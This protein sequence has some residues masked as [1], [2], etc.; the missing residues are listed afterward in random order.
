MGKY[1]KLIIALVLIL[2]ILIFSVADIN[3]GDGAFLYIR[4]G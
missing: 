3:H 4:T 2:I 1:T